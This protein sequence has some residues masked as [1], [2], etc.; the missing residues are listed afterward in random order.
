MSSDVDK[1]IESLRDGSMSLDEIARRFRKRSWPRRKLQPP[2]D[3]ME[4]A[5]AAQQDPDTYRSGSFD[6][7]IAAHQD[8]RITDSEYAVLSEAVAESK[9]NE[10]REIG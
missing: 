7:V 6:D 2:T 5:T 10:D 8:G 1:M 3:Y 4:L 9:R